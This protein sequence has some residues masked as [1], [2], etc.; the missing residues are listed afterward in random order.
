M[1]L[2]SWT[3]ASSK[4]TKND[5]FNCI[6]DFIAEGCRQF[7][8]KGDPVL[9]QVHRHKLVVRNSMLDRFLVRQQVVTP[10]LVRLPQVRRKFLRRQMVQTFASLV[11]PLMESHKVA[12]PEPKTKPKTQMYPMK[13]QHR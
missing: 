13:S 10:F 4:L 11:H 2:T 8:E 6:V 1:R 3:G 7:G 12:C 5:S 9:P